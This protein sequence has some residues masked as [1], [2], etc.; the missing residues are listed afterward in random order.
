MKCCKIDKGFLTVVAVALISYS[1]M[2]QMMTNQLVG[3]VGH[4][5]IIEIVKVYGMSIYTVGMVN[6]A[7]MAIWVKLVYKRKMRLLEER[8]DKQVA[9]DSIESYTVEK[10]DG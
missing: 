3:L 2:F 7:V 1:V 6:I 4:Y 5:E 10:N 8:I 9:I